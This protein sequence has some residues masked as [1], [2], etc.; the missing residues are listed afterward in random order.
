MEFLG[1]ERSDGT[2]GVRNHVVVIPAGRCS[3]ELAAT[4]ADGVKGTVPIL[5][6]HGCFLL[7]PDN[8]RALRTLIGLGCNP[9]V[10]A[11]LVVGIGCE[12][13][14]PSKIGEEIARSKKQVEVVT[15]ED[16]GG[17][18]QVVD[19]GEAAARRMMT[20]ACQMKRKPFDLSHLSVGVKCGGS[21]PISAL[22]GHR[23][24]GWAL[25]TLLSKGGQAIFTET[26][27]VIGAEHVLAR[28]AVNQEVRQRL[29]EIVG[30][31]EATIKA[32]GVDIRGTQPTPGNIENGLSTLEEKSL[33]A[34]VK[35][36][37]APLQG[38]LE[39]AERPQGKG[40]FFMDCS[41]W[42]SHL[43]L[44]MAAA[45]AQISVFSLGGG[46][47]ASFRGIPG[48]VWLPIIPTLTVVSDPKVKQESEYF[49]SY[50]GTIIEGEESVDHAGSCF[51]QE[52]VNVASGKLTKLEMGSGYREV[53]EIY[54]TGPAM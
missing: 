31:M 6:N 42:T 47:P 54:T 46:L 25:D 41:A 44:G 30:R 39:Y 7:K 18:Q 14:S 51:F 43:F 5:H 19:R 15:I 8:E 16:I 17:F 53:M 37:S 9:N 27:E 33:G 11:A 50:A 45:G 48:S 40:L 1:Y 28:R 35:S 21:A 29:L 2:V 22:A 20:Q 52:L 36:G 24:I 3:N 26:T 10:A 38:V 23:S 12:S 13:L 49:D 32:T 4:I 34:I